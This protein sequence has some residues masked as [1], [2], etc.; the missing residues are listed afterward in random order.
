MAALGINNRK[1]TIT[2]DGAQDALSRRY[3]ASYSQDQDGYWNVEVLEEQGC[4]SYGRSLLEASR[5]IRE[6]LAGWIETV[7]GVPV[8][9]DSVLSIGMV[10][11]LDVEIE[12]LPPV[13]EL[14][15]E[16][17]SLEERQAQLAAETAQAVR[18]LRT[19]LTVRDTATALG[20]S[21]QRVQQLAH[22]T[23]RTSGQNV[24]TAAAGH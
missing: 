17:S 11:V 10:L 5:R 3:T 18:A 22:Q 16:R 2:M 21:H 20:I 14:R 13:D 4:H 1:E 6:A 19:V 24:G 9:D 23:T 12:G 8:P 7:H 15:R